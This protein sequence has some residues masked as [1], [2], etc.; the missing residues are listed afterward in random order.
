M[1]NKSLFIVA[2]VA[3]VAAAGASIMVTSRSSRESAKTAAKDIGPLVP[4]LRENVNNVAKIKVRRGVVDSSLTKTSGDKPVW[5][6]ESRGNYPAD[7]DP[8][9][10]LIG[11]LA[12][13]TV[14]EAKTSKPE[15]YDRLG[16]GDFEKTGAAGTHVELADASGK[17]IAALI[18][19]TTSRE[20]AGENEP[21]GSKPR[22][23]IKKDGEAQCYLAKGELGVQAEPMSW[24]SKSIL[25]VDGAKVKSVTVTHPAPASPATAPMPDG[26]AGPV[27][28]NPPSVVAVGRSSAAEPK[29]ALETLPVGRQLKDESRLAG[30]GQA[31]SNLVMDDVMPANGM[32]FSNPEATVEARLFDG[33]VITAKMVT[34]ENKKWWAVEASYEEPGTTGAPATPEAPKAET[35]AAPDAAPDQAKETAAKAEAAKADAVKAEAEKAKA[36]EKA[37]AIKKVAEIN[38]KCGPWAYAL[39]DYKVTQMLVK[40]EELLK[41]AEALPQPVPTAPAPP[42]PTPGDGGLL[43]SPH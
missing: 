25:E 1:R 7:F 33:Q 6:V 20:G 12:E 18:I 31:L 29:F 11:G 39:P 30:I 8:I 13:A 16:V 37:A 15:L 2:A 4:G 40:L 3:A 32:D 17:P 36:D 22:Y 21:G 38:E 34:K 27:S 26:S 35:P 5:V 24:V 42:M 9:R 23:F 10:R 43:Q 41:P 14:V 28:A 19:G